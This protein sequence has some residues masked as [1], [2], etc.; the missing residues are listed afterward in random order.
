MRMTPSVVL[1]H[2]F[3]NTGR[4]WDGVIAALPDGTDTFAPDIRGHGD[5]SAQRP[6]TL[7]AVIDDIDRAAPDPFTLVGYSMGG[8][9]ALHVAFGLPGRVRRLILIGASPG[10]K[11]A[12]ARAERRASD[13]KLAE[14]AEGETIERFVARWAKTRVLADQPASVRDAVDADRRRNDPAGLAAALRGLGTGALPSLWSRLGSLEVP[15]TLVVGER[16]AKFREIATRMAEE[17]R[18]ARVVIVPGAGHAVHA[19]APAAVA[20]VIAASTAPAGRPR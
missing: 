13:A 17:I 10:L 8:R 20:D 7:E 1:L 5:A 4:S 14:R 12:T 2:G 6:V 11:T 18:G 3:T 15:V 9:I 19:E 16:D